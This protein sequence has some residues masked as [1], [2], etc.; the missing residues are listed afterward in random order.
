MLKLMAALNR[1]GILPRLLEFRH[2]SPTS[3]GCQHNSYEKRTFLAPSLVRIETCDYGWPITHRP[4]DMKINRYL[5]AQNTSIRQVSW[6]QSYSSS[7]RHLT[8]CLYPL[9]HR[10]Q[11]D[12]DDIK[13]DLPSLATLNLSVAFVQ[14]FLYM[15]ARFEIP[16]LKYLIFME[17]FLIERPNLSLPSRP[18]SLNFPS[19]Q[20]LHVLGQEGIFAEDIL[21]VIMAI[22][23]QKLTK[24][25]LKLQPSDNVAKISKTRF[26]YPLVTYVNIFTAPWF[27]GKCAAI[28]LSQFDFPL[29]KAL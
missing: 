2:Y 28:L 20:E 5:M 15:L 18:R 27:R 11:V 17:H 7:L 16:K 26:F 25:V 1:M 19:L 23:S 22:A 24:L 9:S 12:L 21:E 29:L 8:L 14:D 13:V 10:D 6:L 3:N 4:I